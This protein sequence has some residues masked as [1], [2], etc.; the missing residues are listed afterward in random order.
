MRGDYA[1]TGGVLILGLY[2]LPSLLGVAIFAALLV[3]RWGN[4]QRVI[5]TAICLMIFIV[6][7]VPGCMAGDALAKVD[8]HYAKRWCDRL[9]DELETIREREGAY[10]ARLSR[11]FLADREIPALLRDQIQYLHESDGSKFSLQFEERGGFIP[12]VHR[13]VSVTGGWLILPD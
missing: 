4:L 2:G 1:H 12:P 3:R 9:A 13:Y 11:A 10:P 8:T 7:Q 6:L 5:D